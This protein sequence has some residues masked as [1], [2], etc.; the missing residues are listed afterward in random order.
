MIT[1]MMQML[2]GLKVVMGYA[3]FKHLKCV[4]TECKE[5]SCFVVPHAPE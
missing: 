3:F 1:H 4:E 5:T 2:S